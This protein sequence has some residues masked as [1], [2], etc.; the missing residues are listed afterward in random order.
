ML[1]PLPQRLFPTQLSD[2]ERESDCVDGL[3]SV[4][5]DRALPVP[6]KLLFVKDKN[7]ETGNPL[8][9]VAPKVAPN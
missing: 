1:I 4:E 7:P 2:I 9:S 6:P 8:S 3:I 5:S